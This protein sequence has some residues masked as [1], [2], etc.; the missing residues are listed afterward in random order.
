[1]K[2]K[3]NTRALAAASERR[4]RGSV[5]EVNVLRG[6]A[7]SDLAAWTRSRGIKFHRLPTIRTTTA[8]LKMQCAITIGVNPVSSLP[9]M[10]VRTAAAT[11]IDGMTNGVTKTDCARN[12][13]RNRKTDTAQVI[14]RATA[15][16][17]SVLSVACQMVNHRTFHVDLEVRC[18]TMDE[19]EVAD[20]M[21][22]SVGS[23]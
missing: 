23:A 14:G 15:N 6:P 2:V 9:G 20:V 4:R 7:P 13:P 8:T 21:R 10:I 17:T 3:A 19:D 12:R 11:T 5:T 18:S 16:V 1:M 22:F